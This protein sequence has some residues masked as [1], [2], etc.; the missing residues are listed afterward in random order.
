VTDA[1]RVLVV[2]DDPDVRDL[3]D[4]YLSE[5]GYEV[6]SADN[7]AMA[8]ALREGKPPNLVVLDVGLPGEDGLRIE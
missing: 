1:V 5:Q 7:A 2:D 8:R 6:L 3:L 4:D